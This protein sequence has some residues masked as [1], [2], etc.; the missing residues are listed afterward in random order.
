MLKLLAS[1]FLNT[2]IMY[3]VISIYFFEGAMWNEDGLIP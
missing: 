3:Y 1:Q 2:A